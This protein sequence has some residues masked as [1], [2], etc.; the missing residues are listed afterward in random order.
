MHP[1]V[2]VGVVL[3]SLPWVLVDRSFI[4]KWYD[5]ELAIAPHHRV[6]GLIAHYLIRTKNFLEGRI[7]NISDYLIKKMESVHGE[8]ISRE[9]A[10]QKQ[11]EIAKTLTF[12]PSLIFY[13][14][15]NI[16]LVVQTIGKVIT[17]GSYE[18][19]LRSLLSASQNFS[20]L[21]NSFMEIYE[22]YVFVAD[23][24]WFLNLNSK[25]KSGGKKL[26]RI[27][28]AVEL[29]DIWFKYREDGGWV[30]K[31]VSAKFS[32]GDKV[33]IVG[34]NGA[35]KSTLIKVLTRFYDPNKGEV[36]VDGLDVKKIEHHSYQSKF[37][38]LFQDF[39]DFAFSARESIGYGDIERI[40]KIDE[41]KEAA[42]KVGLHSYIESLPL[43][44]ENPLSPHFEKGAQLSGGQWQRMGI[45]RI[46]FRQTA[47]ILILDEPTSNVDSE[48]EE[49]IFNE[50]L[51]ISKSKILI[52]VSQRFSTV[53]RADKIVVVDKGK[54]VGE[55][56]H[57]DLMKKKGKY[58]RLFSLQAKGY[59]NEE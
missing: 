50:L 48:A 9:L 59:S 45:A 37:A 47:Q 53:R 58:A 10:I 40:G 39:E 26:T 46:L 55:G 33:A 3:I 52:F 1:L 12:F 51:K 21:T 22:N 57:Q 41:I 44:Y 19:F 5:F 16:F 54:I 36:L 34:E 28:N 30:L 32:V 38:V 2:A 14:A 27:K 17:V 20:G 25:I 49:K 29:R 4:R 23:L 15:V 8:I 56:T 31:G 35:G 7:L 6:R 13:A 18:L 24:Y 42:K 11:Q 43:K